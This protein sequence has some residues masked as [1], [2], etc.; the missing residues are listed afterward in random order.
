LP[1][2]VIALPNEK[3]Y[4][5][6]PTQALVHQ[7]EARDVTVDLKGES[8]SCADLSDAGPSLSSVDPSALAS[9][10]DT[11]LR[12]I[13]HVD[14][15]TGGGQVGIFRISHLGGH[16]Y[17]GVMIICFPSGAQLYYGRVSPHEIEKVVDETILGGKVL[18]GLLRAGGNVV[19]EGKA[20]ENK[21]ILAW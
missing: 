2:P 10:L 20:C 16:R 17:A 8:L 7:L 15:V 19:K 5:Q 6:I 3:A 13:S 11:R 1:F 21:G 14:D 4:F 12:S 18:A 9:E